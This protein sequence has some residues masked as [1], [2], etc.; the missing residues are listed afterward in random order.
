MTCLFSLCF[1]A[2]QLYQHHC[3]AGPVH[4][5]AGWYCH[6]PR[7]TDRCEGQKWQCPSLSAATLLYCS[8]WGKGALNVVVASFRLFWL[9]N[10]TLF[11]L[12]CCCGFKWAHASEHCCSPCIGFSP[13][14]L[15]P[16]S[17]AKAGRVACIA[18]SHRNVLR[19]PKS[20][21]FTLQHCCSESE[22]T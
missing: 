4:Q 16:P 12:C 7:G 3:G 21:I 10:C 1:S 17:S 22:L 20:G 2:P 14:I 6:F 13:F 18:V 15:V 5:F 9:H 11:R 8:K 19:L